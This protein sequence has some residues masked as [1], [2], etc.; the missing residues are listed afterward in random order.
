MRPASLTKRRDELVVGVL[1]F[2]LII[3]DAES[4]KDKRRV[5]RSVKDR[6]HRNHQV[7]VA[8]V[9][10][11]DILNLA[12]MGLAVVAPDGGRAGQVLDRIVAKLKS[13]PDAELGDTHREILQGK[14]GPV[15][16][17]PEMDTAGLAHELIDMMDR[18]EQSS[19]PKPCDG[20]SA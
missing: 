17:S 8:E 14:S 4:L 11:H 10:T 16:A 20:A 2:E 13:T 12:T 9:G 19:Q 3:H 5:V 1:Q 18:A 7:S 6:L 15:S